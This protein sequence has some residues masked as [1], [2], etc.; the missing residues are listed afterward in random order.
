[1][2]MIAKNPYRVLG[3]PITA[4]DKDIAKR[5]SDL[6]IYAEMGKSKK[7]DH[8]L[9]GI[10]TLK[11]TTE[12]IENATRQ[13][14]QP[15]DKLLHSL[16]WFSFDN[17]DQYLK[18]LKE[19]NL[20]E[21][22]HSIPK[23]DVLA[24]HN[25]ALLA[26]LVKNDKEIIAEGMRY[27]EE[28]LN[29]EDL[30]K[31]ITQVLGESYTKHVDI[32]DLFIESFLNE[33]K[34][35][36]STK[37]IITLF[38][39]TSRKEY[40]VKKLS[41]PYIYKLEEEIEL[42]RSKIDNTP[43]DAY[44]SGKKLL[45]ASHDIVRKL[46]EILDENHMGLISLKN[47]LAEQILGCSIAYFNK[48]YNSENDDIGNN[49]IELAEYAR[50]LAQ[51]NMLKDRIYDNLTNMEKWLAEKPKREKENKIRKENKEIMKLLDNSM[52]DNSITSASNLLSHA[53]ELLV[54]IR[55]KLGYDDEL[56]IEISSVVATVSIN[57]AIAWY[58]NQAN[59]KLYGASLD[60]SSEMLRLISRIKDLRLN[61]KTKSHVEQN[62]RIIKQNKKAK[63]GGG[64]G[65]YIA[66]MVYGSYNAPEVL[67]LRE[68]RDN[69]L[70]KTNI[71]KC[72]I[73]LYYKYS[74]KFVEKFK[75]NR[76]INQWI[77]KILNKF[78]E[79]IK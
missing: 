31:F 48:N 60:D 11:R 58:N 66:T 19:D 67:V 21:T 32:D 74:P 70:N 23:D 77:K 34:N 26:L 15:D 10:L 7:F 41:Q 45:R 51:N 54:D 50:S 76:L 71:G 5:T 69:K 27:F 13:L 17:E 4:S 72:F 56:Y 59:I 73:K 64:G 79:V 63:G 25:K 68:F 61:Y 46:E 62:E 28:L 38:Q 20:I 53:N 65:C 36:Y 8:D 1:M 37:E 9:T 30:H 43:E 47:K 22:M 35:T 40:V 49:S 33:I 57:L 78:I 29:H 55:N 24:L 3:L 39:N 16:F 44:K 18:D 52:R 12:N 75:H 14:E 42:T 6:S 2:Q